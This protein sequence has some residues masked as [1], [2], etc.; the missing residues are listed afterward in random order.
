MR[1]LVFLVDRPD[2]ND[3]A[4]DR[5]IRATSGR[6]MAIISWLAR[7]GLANISYTSFAVSSSRVEYRPKEG[8]RSILLALK[9][10]H[11]PLF[12]ALGRDSSTYLASCG[13][14]HLRLSKCP[15]PEMSNRTIDK[16]M[17]PVLSWYTAG[18]KRKKVGI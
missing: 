17:K 4:Y 7:K 3:L 15:S 1:L 14:E 5:P 6:G 9:M 8:L 2:P 10:A 13:I 18:C 11:N 16:L 12:L